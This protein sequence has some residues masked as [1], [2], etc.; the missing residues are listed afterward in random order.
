MVSSSLQSACNL[1]DCHWRHKTKERRRQ[2]KPGIR[3]KGWTV[4][5]YRPNIPQH[6]LKSSNMAIKF[7]NI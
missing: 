6:S 2:I 1:S 7:G 4:S 3:W 5:Q